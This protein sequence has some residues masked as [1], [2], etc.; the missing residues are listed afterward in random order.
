MNSER[1]ES[2]PFRGGSIM[3]TKRLPADTQ[4]RFFTI[5]PIMHYVKP[6]ACRQ[7]GN[8]SEQ[9]SNTYI[10]YQLFKKYPIFTP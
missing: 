8:I 3:A 7:T 9:I 5:V 2:V 6:P 1:L 4:G 10:D